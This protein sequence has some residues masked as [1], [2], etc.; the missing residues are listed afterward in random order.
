LLGVALE[1]DARNLVAADLE[2]D[3]RGDLV[4]TPFE[5]WPQKR[6][7]LK[8]LH[9]ELENPGDWFF[10]PQRPALPPLRGAVGG[11]ADSH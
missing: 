5:A 9:N 3:G 7:T 2:A 8:G 11:F 10:G 6:Q 4:L 1:Q